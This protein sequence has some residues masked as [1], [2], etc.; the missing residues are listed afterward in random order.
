ME[1]DALAAA[2]QSDKQV[3][4]VLADAPKWITWE[5]ALTLQ[6]RD[7]FILRV[8]PEEK[9]PLYVSMTEDIFDADSIPY[10]PEMRFIL[11]VG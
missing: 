4:I 8:A 9:F 3:R 11:R 5:S 10:D 6:M 2:L 7:V 1:L